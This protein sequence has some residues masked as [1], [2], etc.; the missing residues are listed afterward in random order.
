MRSK[1]AFLAFLI[2]LLAAGLALSSPGRSQEKAYKVKVSAEQAN[3]REKPDINS[4]IVQQ[5][6]QGTILE[7]DKKEGEWFHVLYTLEDGGVIGG[8]IHE[9]LVT[10]E[11]EKPPVGEAMRETREPERRVEPK[12]SRRPE[13]EQAAGGFAAG[14]AGAP[15]EISLSAGG[16]AID[17]DDLNLGARGLAGFTAASLGVP[18][19]GTPNDLGIALLAGAEASYRV[20]P[21]LA[22]GLAVDYVRGSRESSVDFTGEAVSE[23]LTTKPTVRVVPV[24][25]GVRFYPGSGFYF[26]GSLGYYSVTASY[27]YRLTQSGGWQEWRGSAKGHT[28]GA[29]FGLGGDWT[30]GRRTAVFAEASY[31]MASLDRLTGNEVFRSSAGD[32]ITTTGDLW[33]Y[34]QQGA[35]LRNYSLLFIH[36]QRPTGD[37]VSSVSAA[38]LNLSGMIFRAG[39]RFRF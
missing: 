4:T 24:K 19:S 25:A 15:F 13:E 22:V 2:V 39:V 1:K 26:K 21:W 14:A 8:W 11:E 9:S 37:G 30:V 5:I 7:A 20:T 23:R 17:P 10:V 32:V 38:D 34:S 6:P 18:A 3:L 29:E 16:G 31:R 33:F 35:D 12:P 27:F 28:L 36:A